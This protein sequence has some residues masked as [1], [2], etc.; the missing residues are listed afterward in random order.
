[1]SITSFTYKFSIVI[2]R[3]EETTVGWLKQH[4]VHWDMTRC[5]LETKHSPPTHH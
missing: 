2:L 5:P 1:M 3:T 4:Q